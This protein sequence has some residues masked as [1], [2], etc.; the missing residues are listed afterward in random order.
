MFERADA[1]MHEALARGDPRET[2]A[3]S[4]SLTY[5]SRLP[6]ERL[7]G[8]KPQ[9]SKKLPADLFAAQ[10]SKAILMMPPISASTSTCLNNAEAT[11]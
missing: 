3:R 7:N 2:T 4:T 1:P 6:S 10:V 8:V 11:P 5:V 9:A